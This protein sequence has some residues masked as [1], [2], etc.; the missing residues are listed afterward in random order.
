MFLKIFDLSWVNNH[1]LYFSYLG[2]IV[3]FVL[4]FLIVK[5]INI[6][7]KKINRR[8]RNSAIDYIRKTSKYNKG[9]K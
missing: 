8:S 5:R 2:G 4:L 6:D 3:I 9:T 1:L 7:I